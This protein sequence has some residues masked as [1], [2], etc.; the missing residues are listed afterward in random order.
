MSRPPWWLV[1]AADPSPDPDLLARFAAD[2]DPAAFEVLVWRHGRMV[3]ATCRRAL[4]DHHAA[5]DAFQATFLILA[6]KAGGVRGSVPAWLHR[7]ARRVA[8]RAAKQTRPMSRLAADP[9]APAVPPPDFAL[10]ALLDE[11]IDRLPDRLRRPVVLCYLDGRTTD[12]AAGLLGVPRGTVLSRLSA[13]RATLTARLTRR[14]VTGPAALLAAGGGIE[15]LAAGMVGRCVEQAVRYVGSGA[16]G[17]PAAIL[18][19]GVMRT[20]KLKAAVLAG[21]LMAATLGVGTGVGV[22]MAQKAASTT[23]PASQPAKAETKPPAKE[24]PERADPKPAEPEREAR[25]Q[26]DIEK[27]LEKLD[28]EIGIR[29]DELR[30]IGSELDAQFYRTQIDLLYQQ[31]RQLQADR[32]RT[33]MVLGLFRET[34][35]GWQSAKDLKQKRE[36]ALQRVAEMSKTAGGKPDDPELVAARQEADRLQNEWGSLCEGVRQVVVGVLPF[37]PRAVVRKEYLMNESESGRIFELIDNEGLEVKAEL[38]KCTA[39]LEQRQQILDKLAP[40]EELR[41]VLARELMVRKLQA[42]GVTLSDPA[43]GSESA[44]VADKLDQILR[45]LAA[46]RAEVRAAAKK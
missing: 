44:G 5:E 1:R 10:R 24:E 35:A 20:A 28:F 25:V 4:A 6:R 18:A 17:G 12:E 23:A 41:R 29:R 21:G 30:R 33:Q 14:G 9:P 3:Y 13:A 15:P 43:R 34:L 42:Q 8:A 45:E 37:P 2:R 36:A 22:V 39:V 26:S 31:V 7:V 19:E 16:A 27:Q 40:A 11:E 46:L 38:A 32:N